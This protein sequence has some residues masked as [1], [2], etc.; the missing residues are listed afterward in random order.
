MLPQLAK[1]WIREKRLLQQLRV[2]PVPGLLRVLWT[3]LLP[4]ESNSRRSA[5]LGTGMERRWQKERYHQIT[6]VDED[7]QWGHL[8]PHQEIQEEDTENE[9]SVTL[10]GILECKEFKEAIL[11]R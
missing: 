4:G 1:R 11:G 2:L 7:V 3:S 9:A 10:S 8:F 5:L 6:L